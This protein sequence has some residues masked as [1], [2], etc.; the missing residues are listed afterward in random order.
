ML[1]PCII[2]GDRVHLLP[3]DVRALCRRPACQWTFNSTP[4]HARCRLCER[5][6][7]SK[8]FGPRLCDDADCQRRVAAERRAEQMRRWHE[9]RERFERRASGV[10]SAT[11]PS[12]GVNDPDGYDLARVPYLPNRTTRLP[13]RRR[14]AYVV[15]LR[16]TVAQAFAERAGGVESPD[17]DLQHDQRYNVAAPSEA[18]GVVL[19]RG[20]AQCRGA[21]CPQGGTR[22]FIDAPTIARY[23]AQHPTAT[24]EEV[25]AA[26][27]GYLGMRTIAEGC[28]NQSAR[29]CTLPREMRSTICN[30][31]LCGGLRELVG[32]L[33][34]RDIGQQDPRVFYQAGVDDEAHFAFVDLRD[35]RIVRRRASR[36]ATDALDADAPRS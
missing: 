20:C 26:Y 25:V 7:T 33:V 6:L 17:F 4:T 12:L 29:G 27:L 19:G 8:Q 13:A 35:V 3:R 11:A 5:P 28:V 14:A 1:P 15:H 31:F 18:I 23:L 34:E 2:C 16:E 22:A 21:C 30:N 24:E 9:A 32:R 36:I 10:R